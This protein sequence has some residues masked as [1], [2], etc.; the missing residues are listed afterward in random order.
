MKKNLRIVLQFLFR[1]QKFER[2]TKSFNVIK[3]MTR[4]RCLYS[5]SH[6]CLFVSI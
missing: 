2:L 1:G 6:P 3:D 5:F 4:L